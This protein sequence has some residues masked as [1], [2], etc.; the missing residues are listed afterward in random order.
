M[1]AKIQISF[2]ELI[3]LFSYYIPAIIFYAL[4]IS[5]IASIATVFLR[6]SADNELIALFALGYPVKKL[7]YPLAFIAALFSILLFIISFGAMPQSKQLYASFKHVKKEEM[8]FNVI[9]EELGQKFGKH[10]IYIGGEKDGHYQQMVIYNQDRDN[11]DQIFAA[12]SG[13]IEKKNG[14][15]S[16]TLNNG[17]GYTF[18]PDTVQ[19][20]NYEKLQVYDT[21]SRSN[22]QFEEIK[23][24]WKKSL[25]DEQ[26]KRKLLFFFFVSLIP[27]L[28]LYILASFTIINPRY[29]KNRSFVIIG[30]VTGLFYA[31]ASVL[32]KMGSIPLLTVMIVATGALGYWLFQKTVSRYF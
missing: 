8:A 7:M 9:P 23:Q 19:K 21:L 14:I 30:L 18:T 29:Q 5:F 4:P 20:I 26:R 31:L 16:L 28:S 27:L 3:Q 1:T 6:L 22:Y 25:S 2:S 10:Y 24:Y 12:N 32:N 13:D 11:S 15:F 17:Q